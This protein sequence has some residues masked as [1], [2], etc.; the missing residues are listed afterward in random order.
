MSPALWAAG[1]AV[2][3]IATTVNLGY[4]ALL[5]LGH[6]LGAVNPMQDYSKLSYWRPVF[7]PLGWLV[8]LVGC[9]VL[10]WRAR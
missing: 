3:G 9:G 7:T 10:L 5:M 6:L 1:W 4:L 8:V 2:L